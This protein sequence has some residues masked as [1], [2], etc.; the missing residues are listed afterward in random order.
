MS[1]AVP[2][3]DSEVFSRAQTHS[4]QWFEVRRQDL[5]IW[6][7]ILLDSDASLYQYPFWN[8]PYRPL[9]VTP[10]YLAW[11]TQ[12]Q[13]L[14]FVSILTVGFG[15]LK[16]GLVFRGPTWIRPN[17]KNEELYA[18][19]L[20]AWARSQ[21]YIFIR[22]THSDPAVL[23]QLGTAGHAELF[24]AFPYFLDYPV[25]SPDYIVEQHKNDETTMAS[26]DREVRRKV[27]RAV[28]SGYEFHSSDSPE[29]LQSVWPLYT[30]CAR[31]KNF[32]LERPL[33]I[34]MEAVRLARKH[35]CV[36]IYSAQLEGK[37]V[38]STLIFRDRTTAHC[39]LA[40]FEA[41]HRRSAVALH[42]HAMR[43]MYRLGARRYNLGPGPGSLARFKQQF[44]QQP[45]GY[46]G[47]LTVVLNEPLFRIWQRALFP[48]ARRLRPTLR[49]LVSRLGN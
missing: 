35:N 48:L 30:D 10:H 23:D 18:R 41:A 1:L 25:Q 9:L 11:G 40:A 6:N 43:D 46:P 20:I 22:F 2:I 38:G 5:A 36:R 49:A 3:P 14:A 4:A 27:R 32:R 19:K 26:L 7:E 16:I 37:T 12:D 31:R 34:Y 21:G 24:D 47:P 44:C 39:Q 15:P 8:E 45:T 42:W 29:E 28:E 13:P 33:P 17:R